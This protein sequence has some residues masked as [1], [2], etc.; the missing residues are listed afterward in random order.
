MAQCNET[1]VFMRRG[2]VVALAV[3]VMVAGDVWGITIM[4]A[5]RFDPIFGLAQVS[6]TTDP[7]SHV[8]TYSI[9]E[10]DTVPTELVSLIE[11]DLNPILADSG[12]T[13]YAVWVPVQIPASAPFAG[14]AKTQLALMTAWPDQDAP[15]EILESTVR[16]L[17]GVL[18]VT[19]Q[20]L[21]PIYLAEGLAVP[22]GAGFYVHR[23][24]L[25]HPLDVDDAVRLSQ[26][27]WETWEPTFGTRVTSLF[28]EKSDSVEVARLLRIV[29]YRSYDGWVDSRDAARAP[30][31]RRR[32]AARRL[33]QLEGSG[34][35]IATNRAGP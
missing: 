1:E 18:A 9:V 31:A 25:Y 10:T 24:E 30:D 15:V 6:P 26:E 14:L 2:R 21:V 27:A 29:W 23:E 8:F 7:L 12:A 16:G 28:R 20:V 34:T 3:A 19:S 11:T 22:T 33:L 32:F 17:D 4:Q 35:A 13:L 5:Q